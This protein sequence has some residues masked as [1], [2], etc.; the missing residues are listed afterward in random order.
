ML[1]KKIT[2]LCLVGTLALGGV[3]AAGSGRANEPG[4]GTQAAEQRS[5]QTGSGLEEQVVVSASPAGGAEFV[6]RVSEPDPVG[7]VS[8]ANLSGR[9]RENNFNVLSLGETIASIEVIDYEK[10]TDTIRQSL[11]SIANAQ[12]MLTITGN[13]FASSSLDSSYNSLRETFEDL[14]DGVVQED[15]AAVIRQLRN[16]QDQIVMAG[17]SLYIALTEMELN[18]GALDRQLAALDRTIQELELRYD[19]GQISALTL[20]QTKGGRTALV[21]GQ[22]TLG[23][24]ITNYKTQ[25]ELLIGAEQSGSIRLQKLPQ[26]SGT[27]LSAMDL[28]ADLETAQANSYELFDAQRTLKDARQAYVDSGATDDLEDTRYQ[29]LSARHTWQAAQHT[30]NAT[31][32]NFEN[33][34]RMLYNQVKDYAQVLS[35]ARTALSVEQ[36]SYAASQLKYDQGTLSKNKLLEAA[37]TLAAAQEKV[38]SAAIDLFSAYNNYRWAVDYGI[39]N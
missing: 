35:A 13:S 2:A 29:I 24:N 10:M 18:D 34:F 39:L 37:D 14:R 25:L 33:R 1:N 20:Q 12:W 4:P 17:E 30:Y 16:A 5:L 15:N 38:D 32:Q 19:L 28:E 31:I 27:Q 36:D 23:M 3:S 22:Q 7:T 21:S 6:P 8:F 26:V 9:M 11:N